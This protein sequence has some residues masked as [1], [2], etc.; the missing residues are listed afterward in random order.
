MLSP[1]AREAFLNA[2]FAS[3]DSYVRQRPGPTL[4]TRCGRL[5]FQSATRRAQSA[6]SSFDFKSLHA[7][8]KVAAEAWSCGWPCSAPGSATGDPPSPGAP[9]PD[10]V[11]LP[12]DSKEIKERGSGRWSFRGYHVQAQS[13]EEAAAKL[14]IHYQEAQ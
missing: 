6:S 5:K 13:R 7:L 9:S 2:V 11:P 10:R 1:N 8:W 14:D 12:P 3:L 4:A